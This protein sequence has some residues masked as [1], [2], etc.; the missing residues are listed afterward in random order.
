MA[1][2]EGG[3]LQALVNS[4]GTSPTVLVQCPVANDIAMDYNSSSFT[5]KEPQSTKN[6]DENV[7]LHIF[8]K[9]A[10]K[11]YLILNLLGVLCLIVGS[12][13]WSWIF[14]LP[15]CGILFR[16][17]CTW[18]WNG[19]SSKCNYH[20]PDKPSCPWCVAPV[21]TSW[22]AEWGSCVIMIITAIIVV[23]R[24]P[25]KLKIWAAPCV[26]I[27]T[28]VVFNFL[29]ALVFKAVYNYPIFL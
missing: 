3:Y 23:W 2:R 29:N 28:W 22:V 16:C 6:F 18:R 25:F 14:V 4:R 15:Y 26:A 8:K 17:G 12:Y 5:T 27:I 24:L 10:K 1:S 9:K 11:K 19:A 13:L 7:D 20:V 21:A